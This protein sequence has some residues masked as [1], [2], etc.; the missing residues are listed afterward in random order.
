MGLFVNRIF[1]PRVLSTKELVNNGAIMFSVPRE[2]SAFEL[3]DQNQQ[4]F[5]NAQLLG[6]WTLVFF[7]FTQC[8]DICPATLAVFNALSKQLSD[9]EFIDDTQ[10]LFVSLDPARD[11]PDKIKPYLNYFN[12]DFI[13]VTGEFLTIHRFSKELNVAFQKVVT[14]AES[15]DYTIDHGGNIALLNPAG[16]YFGFFKPPIELDK[17]ALTY[18]SVR[19]QNR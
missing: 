3:I 17:L 9:G 2:I 10:F 11:T 16:H 5:T 4:P 14:D 6:K 8:P 13:G 12:Q 7:G 15:G 18:K 1:Q 19:A